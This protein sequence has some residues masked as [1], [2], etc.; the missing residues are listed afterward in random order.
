MSSKPPIWERERLSKDS[1]KAEEN[2]RLSRL[3][4]VGNWKYHVSESSKKFEHLLSLLN[5]LH[6]GAFSQNVQHRVFEVGL[7]EAFRYLAGPP[8]S[9]DD[10]RVIANVSSLKP[11]ILRMNTPELN[12]VFEIVMQS[13][14][15][16][17]FPWVKSKRYPSSQEMSSALLASA[18]LLA[19]QRIAT[20]RRSD[21]KEKQEK[22]VKDY[23]ISIGFTEVA[24]T[25][26]HTIVQGPNTGQFCGECLLGERKT[27]ILIRLHDTRFLAIECKVSNSSTNSVKRLNNDAAVKAEYWIKTFGT[28]QVVPSAMLAGVFNVLNL[29]QAQNRG[30]TLFWSHSLSELGKFI[31]STR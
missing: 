26:I 22:A 2:F 3:D 21:G 10:L 6:P 30:M 25:Q 15:E 13:L 7:A 8:Y 1:D 16:Y 5:N 11:S 9:E 27:D 12:R 18:T 31:S 24:P 17:R 28:S 29:E 14:D 20:E 19:A 23:L 4:A